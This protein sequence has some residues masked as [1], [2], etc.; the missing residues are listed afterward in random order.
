MKD[1]NWIY[2][3]V[4]IDTFSKLKNLKVIQDNGIEIPDNWKIYNHHMTIAF[5]NKS[6]LSNE[7]YVFYQDMIGNKATLTVDG[8]GVSDKA[9]AVRVRWV[10]PIANKIAHVTIA[11]PL[12]G[13]PVN[14]NFITNWLDIQPYKINGKFEQ[15]AK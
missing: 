14:S 2:F 15:F 12:D 10:G 7:L 9:I 13:K 8:I 1:I 3:G 4:F 5:N 6:K 11:T